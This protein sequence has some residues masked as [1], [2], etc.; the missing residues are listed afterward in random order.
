MALALSINKKKGEKTRLLLLQNS[1]LD[2]TKRLRTEGN[3]I[4]FP[5][6]RMPTLA[7]QRG[8]REAVGLFSLKRSGFQEKKLKPRSLE[9]AL[10]GALS[11]EEL[12]GLVTSFD[13][14][15]KI[16]LILVPDNLLAKEK[17]IAR[18]LLEANPQLETVARILGGHEGTFRVRPMKVIAGRKKLET[19]HTEWGCRFRVKVGK[20]FFSPRLS[21]ERARIS[22]LVKKG[23]S[24]GVFF[25]GVGPFAI[26]FAKHSK[27]AK[28]FAVELNPVACELLNENILLNKCEGKVVP[29]EGDVKEVVPA[30]LREKC[31]RVVM[32]LPKGAE[33]FLE[34]AFAALKPGGGVIHFYQFVEKEDLYSKPIG[35][36]RETAKKFG[37]RVRIQNRKIVRSFSPSRVQVVI[38]A[39]V[40]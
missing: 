13:V 31:D 32:P 40:S 15:G 36:L 19:L 37:R 35:L 21:H 1:L 11:S 24:V 14:I 39:E 8:L 27:A 28:V 20:V 29:F 18:A 23:E 16:A 30:K 5:L 33:H 22:S 7:E 26:I 2:T 9:E 34:T 25:A 12:S 38:D 4:L 10:T 3:S 6:K 17:T